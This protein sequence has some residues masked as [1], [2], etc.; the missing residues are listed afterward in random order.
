[1]G[2]TTLGWAELAKK[3][4][5]FMKLERGLSDN[6]IESYLRD[7]SQ[8]AEF[9]TEQF[10]VSPFDVE[11]FMVDEFMM[12]LYDKRVE[13][14]TQSRIL[15]GIKSF[16]NFMLTTDLMDSTPV[17]FTD[18][19]KPDQTLPDTLSVDEIDHILAAI[20]LSDPLGH[21]NKAMIETM[22]S[23]G[24]RVSELTSL[25]FSDLFFD[26]GFIRISAGK[27]DKQRLVPIN[28][29]CI[30]QIMLYLETR[31]SFPVKDAVSEEFVFLNR[32]GKP[33]SRVM[34]FNIIKSAVEKA[35]I[36]KTISPHTFRH[37]FATHL[38]Q[39][40]ASIRQVQELLG[41]ESITTTERYTHLDNDHLQQSLMRHHP[42]GDR[43]PKK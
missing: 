15:S 31:R 11:A 21:R 26:E 9:I 24:L 40:G 28:K 16:Y 13:K 12:S 20:D 1:M 29:E 27:G 8:F 14:S 7:L 42:L 39:G 10:A 43:K 5:I 6:T 2:K 32:R 3:Y 38:L 37:S 4:R 33:L 19:P 41:H 35:G 17:E 34:V 25:K 36:D 23:C 18:H 30:K 22:Y